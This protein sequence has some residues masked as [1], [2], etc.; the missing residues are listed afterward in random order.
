MRKKKRD[1]RKLKIATPFPIEK[2]DRKERVRRQ[3]TINMALP[4]NNALFRFLR[5]SSS[6]ASDKSINPI[7]TKKTICQDIIHLLENPVCGIIGL[8]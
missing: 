2:P 5:C 6:R 4:L 1:K 7:E 8:N 3:P